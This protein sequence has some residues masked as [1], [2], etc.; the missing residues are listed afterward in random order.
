MKRL[1]QTRSTCMY[2]VNG[3]SGKE[4]K[5]LREVSME[6]ISDGRL[7]GPN[8]LVKADCHDCEG[9]F[10]CCSGMG[11]SI[12]L[13]PLDVWRLSEIMQMGFEQMLGKYLE[14]HVVDGVILPN[15][16]MEEGRD[17]CAFLNAQGRCSVHSH[18]PGLCRLFP[19]GRYYEGDS[20]R[21]F[22]Q[23]RECRKDNRSKIKVKKWI[24][25]PDQK[26]YDGFIL[27][28]HHL[29]RRLQEK[30]SE[31][32][33]MEAARKYNLYL[34]ETFYFQGWPKEEDFYEAFEKRRREAVRAL[35]G[36]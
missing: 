14:L 31:A 2:A 33:D 17:C 10:D 22:L 13:D 3:I 18:R 21:Y 36:E 26:R 12:L 24:D 20:F 4:E 5:M 16:K 35:F 1:R 25:T 23:T 27:D 15:L 8:D 28:W 11:E 7:Y 29:V 19:L 9:C 6:E 34:L 32:Y 30:L